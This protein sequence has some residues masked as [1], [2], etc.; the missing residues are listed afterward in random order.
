MTIDI[1]CTLDVEG[2]GNG[3]SVRAGTGGIP[4]EF[5]GGTNVIDRTVTVDNT[6]GGVTIFDNTVD[7]D[8]FDFL[9]IYPLGDVLIE[10]TAGA[11][12]VKMTFKL[13]A[14]WPLTLGTDDAAEAIDDALEV[15]KLINAR[16]PTA[17]PVTVRILALT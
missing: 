8:S 11:A 13:L 5:A 12:N 4:V 15:I 14:G 10:L 17:T 3:H 16:A 7:I 1:R 2:G 9:L 6:A